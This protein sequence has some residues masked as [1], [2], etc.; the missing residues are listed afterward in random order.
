MLRRPAA[1]AASELD[2][3]GTLLRTVRPRSARGVARCELL[4]VDA[5]RSPL[6]GRDP[7]ALRDELVRIADL[8][9]ADV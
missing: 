9:A 4:L 5:F 8:L 7:D 1:C 6:H 3:L 2:G